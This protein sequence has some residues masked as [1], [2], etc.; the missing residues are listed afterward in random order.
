MSRPLTGPV[1]R[2]ITKKRVAFPA[3]SSTRDTRTGSAWISAASELGHAAREQAQAE[4]GAASQKDFQTATRL[5]SN[6]ATQL[7]SENFAVAT[8]NFLQATACPAIRTRG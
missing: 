5:A 3:S 6:G 2:E 1:A 8:Q 7:G 4:Q